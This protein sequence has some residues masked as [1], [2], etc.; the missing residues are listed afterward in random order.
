[1]SSPERN[2]GCRVSLDFT[3]KGYKLAVLEND[4]LR[5][6]TLLDKGGDI[7]EFQHKPSGTDLLWWTPWG[8]YPQGK[9]TP[10]TAL[11][12]GLF[13]DT[14]EGGW[15]DIFPSGGVPNR[16]QGVEY[17]LH[18]ETPL[19]PWEAKIVE[20]TPES[21]AVEL[22]CHTYRT[23]FAL[24]KTLRLKR[25]QAALFTECEAKNLSGKTLDAMWGQHPVFGAPFLDEHCRVDLA[26]GKVLAMHEGGPLGRIAA[27]TEGKWP[28]IAGKDGKAVDVS[29]FPKPDKKSND[30]L[31]VTDLK[32]NWYALTNTK[33]KVGFG[34]V[35]DLKTWPHLW[36]WQVYNGAQGGPFFG[37]TYNCALEPFSSYPSGLANAAKAGKALVFKPHETK[38][39]WY[40]A[41]AYA[42]KT[43][44]A[45]ISRAGAL[46]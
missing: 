8:L 9:H 38:Q 10:S 30:M 5:V 6:S 1:M 23:P 24:K 33:K 15:Q 41:V 2:W 27:G 11:A 17:G 7:V 31:Y 20:D 25:G 13:G 12:E 44:V 18:G 45:G 35:W 36:F 29:K 34:L 40:T 26:G 16:H 37:R 14:Y 43:K 39:A 3:Y 28:K 19:L 21:V 32:S 46:R 4:Q 42:G 22:R